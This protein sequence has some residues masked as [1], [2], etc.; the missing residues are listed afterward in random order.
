MTTRLRRTTH[1][2]RVQ[3]SGEAYS[4]GLNLGQQNEKPGQNGNLLFRVVNRPPG[5]RPYGI[6]RFPSFLDAGRKARSDTV[7]RSKTG[8]PR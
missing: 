4:P 7:S 6:S 8:K 1:S 3:T 5:S 2:K